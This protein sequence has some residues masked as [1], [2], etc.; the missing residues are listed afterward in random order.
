[1]DSLSAW[2]KAPSM[3]SSQKTKA[4]NERNN[5]NPF[6]GLLPFCHVIDA[7]FRIALTK[8]KGC[9]CDDPT[10]RGK[11]K[12]GCGVV[13]PDALAKSFDNCFITAHFQI[14]AGQD[15]G[16]P[17]KGIK[18]MD[19]QRRKG[20]MLGHIIQAADVVLFVGNNVS[21]LL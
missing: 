20:Q 3:V 6:L 21:H 16:H 9:A 4:Q 7:S 13:R 18:P 5:A 19:A 11:G 8:G 10:A 17:Y 2:A 14:L 15:K 1:M 12:Q